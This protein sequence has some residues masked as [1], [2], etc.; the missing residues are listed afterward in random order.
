MA[1]NKSTIIEFYTKY[2]V[3]GK[4]ITIVTF[5]ITCLRTIIENYTFS[6]SSNSKYTSN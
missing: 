5:Q 2:D 1:L 4:A 6:H 3:D